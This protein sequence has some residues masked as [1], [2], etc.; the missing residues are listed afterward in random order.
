MSAIQGVSSHAA[1][2]TAANVRRPPAPKAQTSAAETAVQEATETTT[3]TKAEAAQ[4]DQQ[5]T[6]RLAAA[7]PAVAAGTAKPVAG[8]SGIDLQA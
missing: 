2:Q 8:K 7:Q 1:A 5:A 3:V 4:G 6:R